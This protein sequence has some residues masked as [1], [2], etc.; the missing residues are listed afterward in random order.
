VNWGRAAA[1]AGVAGGLEVSLG[2]FAFARF[3]YS[4]EVCT[5]MCFGSGYYH[6]AIGAIGIFLVLVSVVAF[7]GLAAAFY[8]EIALSTILAVLLALS[9][10]RD[11][12][13]FLWTAL[14]LVLV[15]AV[16]SIVS[17]RSRGRLTEQSNPMNLPVFG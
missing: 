1:V 17:V 8:A 14:A 10:T 11:S 16:L 15:A 6:L 13:A 4:T 7:I 5:G 12:P 9:S 3:A 2:T